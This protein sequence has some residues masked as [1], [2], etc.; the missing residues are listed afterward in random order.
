MMFTNN[1]KNF[2]AG[3]IES[4]LS[5]AMEKLTGAPVAV[6]IDAMDFGNMPGNCVTLSKVWLSQTI[7]VD[8]NGSF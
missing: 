8:E 6:R 1:F 5:E 4:T 3:Q 2:S 7:K